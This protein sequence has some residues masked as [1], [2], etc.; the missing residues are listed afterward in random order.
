[1][2]GDY[3]GA[4]G[5]SMRRCGEIRQR[6][7]T[8]SRLPH[9]PLLPSQDKI[10]PAGTVP[11]IVDDGV[12]LWES[13]VVMEYIND[14]YVTSSVWKAHTSDA[15]QL[16]RKSP[17]TASTT[18]EPHKLPARFPEGIS[19]LPVDPKARAL[20]RMFVKAAD[21]STG[22]LHGPIRNRGG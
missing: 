13:S 17:L 10:C 14:K 5:H 8:V 16:E 12:A 6:T 7:L 4:G 1:V 3:P 15:C 19:L 9:P 18:P 11:A 22:S 20:A 21:G 2:T